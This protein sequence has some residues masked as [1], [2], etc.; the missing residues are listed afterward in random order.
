MK[1]TLTTTL[2]S[3]LAAALCPILQF[4]SDADDAQLYL[5]RTKADVKTQNQAW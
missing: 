5:E 2:S 1:L 4:L 3:V